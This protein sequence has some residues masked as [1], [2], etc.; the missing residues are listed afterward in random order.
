M[1]VTKFM[2]DIMK[3][4]ARQ[5]GRGARTSEAWFCGSASPSLRQTF[6]VADR[7]ASRAANSFRNGARN[8]FTRK[9]NALQLGRADFGDFAF[10]SEPE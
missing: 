6:H 2:H 1:A 10:V 8:Y 9:F 3:T 5:S 4:L 7:S